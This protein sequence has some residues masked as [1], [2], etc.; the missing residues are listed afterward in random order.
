M[1]EKKGYSMNNARS[2]LGG[3]LILTASSI[4]MQT[5]GVSF[6]VWLTARLGAAGIGLFQLI[7]TVYNL[8]VTLGCG[9]VRLA[10]TRL[11][12]EGIARGENVKRTVR[13]CVRYA[14]LVGCAVAA[15]L[16]VFAD[17]A[18][19]RWI[20]NG[21]AA[22]PL[23]ILALSLPF[24]AASAALNGYF[25]A[26]RK[27]GRYSAV[28]ILEQAVRIA[29]VAGL[30]GRLLPRGIR[31]GC[32]AI[33][34]GILAS[35]AFSFFCLHVLYNIEK[36]KY[37]KKPQNFS[38]AG[39]LHVALP[40]VSGAGARSV[41]L[42]VEHLLIPQGFRKSGASAEE[43][44]TLYGNVH[45]MVFPM[46]LYPSAIL[47]SLAG[48]LIPELAGRHAQGL[49]AQI[50]CIIRRVL[51]MTLL[52]AFGTAGIFCAFAD[53][54][55][56]VVYDTA[57]CAFY[58]QILSVLVPVMYC[59]MTV[60]GMLKGLDQQRACMR[61]NIWDSGLCVA[62]VW[63]LLPRLGMKGYVFILFFSEIFNFY[64]SLRR[65]CKVATVEL[66]PANDLI[67][68]LCCGVCAPAFV[69]LVLQLAGI[70]VRSAAS[71]VCSI[72]L[73]GVLYVLLLCG[74]GCVTR[75]DVRWFLNTCG[76]RRDLRLTARKEFGIV[77]AKGGESH[78]I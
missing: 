49:S 31:W 12:V 51:R 53:G 9:G 77:A 61:Y 74:F 36:Q 22:L 43:A 57:D 39:L 44:L 8:A 70:S 66:R 62:L 41:L 35:E 19:V 52:F 65:L 14:F 64:F 17:L 47:S 42:T 26:V 38:L 40:D 60:D 5:V 3:T 78:A 25:T 48:L 75:E 72:A 58:L 54:L 23:R 56:R 27:I 21:E 69:S 28:R 20:K 30:M 10:S 37:S 50:T 55:S 45:G 11:T 71:L 6:N 76:L 68:P 2:I 29:V 32:V 46:L 24:V 59:D 16:F 7:L 63:V 73:S 4:L 13:G 18:A 1:K 67:A 15:L 33:V 34:G